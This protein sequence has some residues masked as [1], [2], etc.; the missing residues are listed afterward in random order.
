VGE[1]TDDEA[2]SAANAAASANAAAAPTLV[3]D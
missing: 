3:V 2:V 1:A